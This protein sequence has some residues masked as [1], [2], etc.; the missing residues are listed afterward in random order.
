[1]IKEET[2]ESIICS[3]YSRHSMLK[4][5]DRSQVCIHSIL[6]D[7][8]NR[9]VLR[10]LS[11]SLSLSHTHIH[12]TR[13]LKLVNKFNELYFEKFSHSMSSN[14]SNVAEITTL[15]SLN[16]TF[17]NS[18]LIN[19][20]K[21]IPWM[22]RIIFLYCALYFIHIICFILNIVAIYIWNIVFLMMFA[23]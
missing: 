3:W 11:F 7:S 1:M 14:Q 18:Y 12:K 2:L 16:I 13:I 10:Y 8:K 22:K 4:T 20:F 21:I 19:I 17:V 5:F 15:S 6:I 9:E 23:K